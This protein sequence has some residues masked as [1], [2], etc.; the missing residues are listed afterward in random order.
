[1]IDYIYAAKGTVEG[2]NFKALF[3]YLTGIDLTW[4]KEKGFPF[5]DLSSMFS[6]GKETL[7]RAGLW[8]ASF[9]TLSSFRFI[10]WFLVDLQHMF[11]YLWSTVVGVLTWLSCHSEL[12][13][14]SSIQHQKAAMSWIWYQKDLE[15][16]QE[17]MECYILN[18]H[19]NH[20]EVSS[21]GNKSGL[22]VGN[23]DPQINSRTYTEKTEWIVWVGR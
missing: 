18:V 10:L 15:W 6:N 9:I 3:Q 17:Q 4:L 23:S 22:A 2:D 14:I 1:M 5:V 16:Q 12:L 21:S 7:W 11:L 19:L 13:F 20:S 8:E